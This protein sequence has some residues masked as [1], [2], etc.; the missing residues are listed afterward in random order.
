MNKLIKL[1]LSDDKKNSE[2]FYLNYLPETFQWCYGSEL[3]IITNE[4]IYK[5]VYINNDNIGTVFYDKLNG[6]IIYYEELLEKLADFEENNEQDKTKEKLK[7]IKEIVVIV[8][9]PKK[10]VTNYLKGLTVYVLFITDDAEINKK[11]IEYYTKLIENLNKLRK[12]LSD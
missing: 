10:L 4:E 6:E 11:E 1:A 9:E 3:N 7:E 8:P 5:L 12:A 2:I